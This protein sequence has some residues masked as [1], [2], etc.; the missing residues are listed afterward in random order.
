[1][2]ERQAAIGAQEISWFWEGMENDVRETLTKEQRIAIEH[3]VRSSAAT[4]RHSD[5]RLHFGKYF[6][7]IT[8]GRERRSPERVQKDIEDYPVF[9]KRNYSVL[10][11]LWTL[12]L[13]SMMYASSVIIKLIPPNAI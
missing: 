5:L 4:P 3:A 10:A 2:S 11:I 7:R 13:L 12:M 8:A 9:A 1:M 6:V